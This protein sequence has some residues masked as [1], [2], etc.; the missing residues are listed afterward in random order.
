MSF[1]GAFAAA[2]FHDNFEYGIQDDFRLTLTIP[3][4][5]TDVNTRTIPANTRSLGWLCAEAAEIAWD[6]I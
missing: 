2:C 1:L 6:S 3:I 4:A 5:F